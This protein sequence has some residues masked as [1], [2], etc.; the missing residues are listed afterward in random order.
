MKIVITGSLGHISKP[1]TQELVKKGHSVTVI[2]SNS[3]RKASIKALGA[4]AAIGTMGNADFL[5]ATFKGADIVYVMETLAPNSFFDPNVDVVAEVT[6][7]GLNYQKAINKSGVKRIVH[8]SSIGAHMDKGNG[9]LAFHHHVERILNQLPDDVAIKF[10]RPVGFYY[11]MLAFIPTIKAQGVIISNYGGDEKE[12]WVSPLDI[13]AVI[14][15]EMEKPFEGRT[16]R[17]IASDEVSANEVASILGEAIGKPDLKWLVVPDEQLLD[18][19]IASGMNPQTA[20]GF[21]EMNA[22]GREGTLYEDYHR[23]R[24]R[25]GKVKLTDFAKEFSKAYFQSK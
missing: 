24:P 12:P 11:N 10:M 8:L 2:S 13:A 4:V 16:V 25:L 20:Q 7:I 9:L 14:A 17:Y 19:L 15:D 6:K 3:E 1:L 18:G 22:A 21:V 23:N 5:A